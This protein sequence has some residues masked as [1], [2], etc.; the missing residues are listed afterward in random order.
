MQRTQVLNLGFFIGIYKDMRHI[1]PFTL[2]EAKTIPGSPIGFI[3]YLRNRWYYGA[4]PT[5]HDFACLVYED[6]SGMDVEGEFFGD[7]SLLK[8][9]IWEAL[10]GNGMGG[11]LA[12]DDIDSASLWWGMTPKCAPN[13]LLE[14]YFPGNPYKASKELDLAFIGTKAIMDKWVNGRDADPGYIGLSIAND[15]SQLERY[16]EQVESE[17]AY[18][19][20]DDIINSIKTDS[21]ELQ[22]MIKYHKIKGLI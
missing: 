20:K 13:V 18:F 19:D 8:H 1:A 10:D 3:L 12:N 15:H 4:F 21:K 17:D 2:N 22:A 11:E 5:F 6:F 9:S 14:H 7:M 16:L